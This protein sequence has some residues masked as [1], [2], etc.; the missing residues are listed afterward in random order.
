MDM[1][2]EEG[3]FSI[4]IQERIP[5]KCVINLIYHLQLDE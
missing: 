3:Y 1:S 2:I 5:E 4:E